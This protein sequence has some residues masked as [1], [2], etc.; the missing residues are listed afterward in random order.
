MPVLLT[1][2]LISVGALVALIGISIL[3]FFFIRNMKSKNP[4][5]VEPELSLYNERYISYI[6][7]FADFRLQ[8]KHKTGVDYNEELLLHL[9]IDYINRLQQIQ[10]VKKVL[11]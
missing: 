7:K 9:W 11:K 3:I 5:K 2:V 8:V 6:K 4:L 1:I 10:K